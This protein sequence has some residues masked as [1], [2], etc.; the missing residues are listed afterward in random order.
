MVAR[1]QIFLTALCG[2]SLVAG[3]ILPWPWLPLLSAT[4][5]SVLAFREAI[6]SLRE[7]KIDVHVLMLLAAI[8]SVAV[9]RP[10]EAAILLFLFSLSNTLEAFAAKKTSSA[11]EALVKLRPTKTTV[12]R[13]GVDQE[14]L[15]DSVL[16][17][18]QIRLMPYSQIPLD[19]TILVGETQ[20]NQVAMTGESVPVARK[21]GDLV[22]AGTQ[23]LDSMV[24]V[25]V[26]VASTE[27]TLS[28][29]VA[30]VQ[31]A[32]ENKASGERI[33]AWFGSRYTVFVLLVF[34]ISL[35]IR[36]TFVQAPFSD[37]LYD[38]LF[39]LVALSP[40]ALVISSPAT[41]LSALAWAARRGILVKGG[42]VIEACG[43]IDTLLMDKT[44]TL[45]A[46]KPTLL[47]V[48]LCTKSHATTGSCSV[49]ELCWHKGSDFSAD[50]KEFLKLAAIAEQ[51]SDHPI[52][53][54][55]R[56]AAKDQ[57]IEIP[58]ADRQTV[59]SGKGVTATV[60][61]TTIRVGQEAFFDPND[62]PAEMRKHLEEMRQNGLTIAL[63]EARGE[64]AAL[65][66]RD[67]V[68]E[69]AAGAIEDL[70]RL[71]IQRIIM[72]T[73]DNKVTAQAIANPLHLDEV[74]ASLLPAQKEHI[75]QRLTREGRKVMMVG[76]G[77]N[78]APALAQA[79][80][81][82][83]RGGL[84]SD[85][86]M[87]SADIVLM[88]DRLARLPELISLGRL[89]NRVIRANLIFAGIV[90]ALLTLMSLLLPQIAPST[91][92]WILPLAVIGHEGSTVI[93]ILNG[94]RLLRGPLAYPK[95]G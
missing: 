79:H 7:K 18:E 28:R 94:L 23:N 61:S 62:V 76:D 29:V 14:V 50:A 16:P 54:A 8:C 63:V 10:N 64:L 77:V 24:I 89:T 22:L 95:R 1:F 15:V 11:I 85:V 42:E 37:A 40:C 87:K 78:D 51:Y 20:V 81:G 30:L 46:G 82:V 5:G 44:G 60:G 13:D 68:R 9:G 6:Q 75:L 70:R 32:Q 74:H 88:H 66:L 45:T 25:L 91:K 35:L 58:E 52:A 41:T 92:E 38:S 17:G 34:G 93:V 26:S 43:S 56:Q 49:H 59:V 33:S 12:I 71:G 53:E 72:A 83:A 4:A 84:G 67:E 3:W 69:E 31:E 19:G 73:G 48:C 65:G 80:V 27:T 36:T 39:L 47:E 21:P 86:A 2:I 90:I 55:I 57:G